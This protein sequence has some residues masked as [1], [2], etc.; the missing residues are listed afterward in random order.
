MMKAVRYTNGDE[1]TN[2][3]K[4]T[5]DEMFE[6]LNAIFRDQYGSTID[7]LMTRETVLKDLKTAKQFHI[8]RVTIEEVMDIDEL[9][10]H[11]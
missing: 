7:Q 1:I 11:S 5:P 2:P 8:F 6:K 9:R 10:D 3:D 4:L